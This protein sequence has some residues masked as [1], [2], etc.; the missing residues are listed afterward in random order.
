MVFSNIN[1]LN[2]WIYLRNTLCFSERQIW[3]LAI[4]IYR[5]SSWRSI[6][7]NYYGLD[8]FIAC[9]ALICIT[10]VTFKFYQNSPAFSISKSDIFSYILYSCNNIDNLIKYTSY[11]ASCLSGNYYSKEESILKTQ[12]ETI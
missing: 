10:I 5:G 8:I 9:S 7:H 11:S 2:H 1:I 12:A 6:N 3:K 4:F